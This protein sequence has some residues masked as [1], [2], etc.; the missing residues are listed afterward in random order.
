MLFA[1]LHRLADRG[2]FGDIARDAEIAQ[3]S[4]A[5]AQGSKR[6][7]RKIFQALLANPPAIAL[8]RLATPGRFKIGNRKTGSGFIGRVENFVRLT[9]SIGR[10]P[11]VGA[12]FVVA[13]RQDL[14]TTIEQNEKM[15]RGAQEGEIG[16]PRQVWLVAIR[17]RPVPI[18]R[19]V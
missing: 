4:V 12:P 10:T 2:L 6:H 3:Q 19:H 8:K 18:A 11:I 7:M 15:P 16:E 14:A 5:F 1:R 9:D 13:Q 17:G